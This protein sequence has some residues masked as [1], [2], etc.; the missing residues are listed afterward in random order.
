MPSSFAN[1]HHNI[2]IIGFII[3]ITINKKQIILYIK[4]KVLIFILVWAIAR[5]YKFY[6]LERKNFEIFAHFANQS[7]L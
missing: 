4:R 6:L 3:I 7:T 1:I 5:L 2:T